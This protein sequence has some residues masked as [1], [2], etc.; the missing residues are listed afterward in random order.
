[1]GVRL[2]DGVELVRGGKNQRLYWL[3][4]VSRNRFAASLW[5]KIRR[6][7]KQQEMFP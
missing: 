2:S 4:F 5:E 6:I 7:D 3:A 1:L